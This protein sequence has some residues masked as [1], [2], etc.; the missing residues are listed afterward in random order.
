MG[1]KVTK[2]TYLVKMEYDKE[3]KI[4]R[5]VGKDYDKRYTYDEKGRELSIIDIKSGAFKICDYT[6]KGYTMRHLLDIYSSGVCIAQYN[7]EG[8]ET[9]RKL[10]EYTSW[11]EYDENGRLLRSYD[12]STPPYTSEYKYD[13]AGRL[14]REWKTVSG[15]TYD[16]VYDYDDNDNII[17]I[18]R[19]DLSTGE[20]NIIVVSEYD[21]NNNMIYRK[22]RAAVD[23]YTYDHKNRLIY[24]TQTKDMSVIGIKHSYSATNDNIISTVKTE[25]DTISI[26]IT[27]TEYRYNICDKVKEI[28]TIIYT[29]N[30]SLLLDGIDM[31]II[32]AINGIEEEDKAIDSIVAT[33][34][35]VSLDTKEDC[36]H[37]NLPCIYTEY[38]KDNG[39][40]TYNDFGQVTRR[41]MGDEIES[42]KYEHGSRLSNY[43]MIKRNKSQDYVD[44]KFE[45]SG[46]KLISIQA[47][48]EINHSYNKNNVE[49]IYDE[50]HNL[51]QTIKCDHYNHPRDPDI[52]IVRYERNES[53]YIG[54][55]QNDK[56]IKSTYILQ[57]GKW[58]LYDILNISSI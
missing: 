32:D 55:E 34:P 49:F 51:I 13:E 17:K 11:N 28:S 4:I 18:T 5:E 24:H 43:R 48:G 19:T 42:F 8:L 25:M 12:D 37:M 20:S 53:G 29:L 3:N 57:K 27:I 35:L 46:N 7:K 39:I 44:Y 15:K 23:R 47:Y 9:M 31:S 30:K 14:S 21:E 41:E 56:S 58:N 1:K 26:T 10:G 45:Y 40:Y 2:T 38:E 6:D 54:I 16:E 36:N 33:I 22:K 52:H 50:Q